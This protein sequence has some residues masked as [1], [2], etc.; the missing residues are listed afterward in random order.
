VVTRK[1][2]ASVGDMAKP[3]LPVAGNRRAP[4]LA[5]ARPALP[6]S[7]AGPR[8]RSIV[9]AALA[10]TN[11]PASVQ[12]D[13]EVIRA[14]LD[15]DYR[16]R[17]IALTEAISRQASALDRIQA[18]LALLLEHS[19]PDLKGRI[20]GL[21]VA[22][23]GS[24]ADLAT[25]TA[26][27][28]VDPIGAGYSLSQQGL[29]DALHCSASDISVLLK[30]HPLKQNPH[31]AVVVRHGKKTAVVNYHRRAIDELL[32]LVERPPQGAARELL[33]AIERINRRRKTS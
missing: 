2:H 21:A 18:T 29:A 8:P 14:E 17:F 16:E 24:S 13:V 15:A 30:H 28:G 9:A 22:P 7:E 10:R 5:G 25:I 1:L 4:K 6:K 12:E 3:L 11:L 23:P 33:K 27:V 20:P 19:A 26:A 32:R 31:M